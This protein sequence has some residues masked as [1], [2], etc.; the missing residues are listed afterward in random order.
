MQSRIDERLYFYSVAFTKT[1][2]DVYLTC[3]YPD[4]KLHRNYAVAHIPNSGSGS[5]GGLER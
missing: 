3:F 4:V 5:M 2:H 1:Q